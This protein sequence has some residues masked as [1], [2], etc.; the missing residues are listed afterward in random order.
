MQF[1]GK[2]AWRNKDEV[3]VE[4]PDR[5]DREEKIDIHLRGLLRQGEKILPASYPDAIIPRGIGV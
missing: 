5:K 1:G 4:C 2:Y 3:E